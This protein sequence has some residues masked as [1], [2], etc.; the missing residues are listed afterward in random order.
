MQGSLD[1]RVAEAL[2]I[3]RFTAE[4]HPR[5]RDGKWAQKWDGKRAKA[6]EKRVE[7]VVARRARAE[8][9]AKGGVTIS[10][11]GDTPHEGYAYAPDASATAGDVKHVQGDTF[12]NATHKIVTDRRPDAGGPR[13][14]RATVYAKGSKGV[15][16]QNDLPENFD[17]MSR[18]EQEQHLT[19]YVASVAKPVG[20]EQVVPKSEFTEDV[21]ADYMQRHDELLKVEGN[22]LGAWESDGQVYLDISRVGPPSDETLKKAQAAEQLAAY[23]LSSGNEITLGHKEGGRYV[24]D[25]K[26]SPRA[27]KPP[28][29]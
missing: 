9:L 12:E 4:L 1:R 3:G 23:D 15:V 7:R 29:G 5:T 26:A 22:Y 21:I 8:T 19:G 14:N 6:L 25:W 20:F 16:A 11:K 24:S 10:L 2:A 27:G 28:S 18:S 17:Q 13:V